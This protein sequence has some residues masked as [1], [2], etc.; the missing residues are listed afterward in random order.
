MASHVDWGQQRNQV[1]LQLGQFAGICLRED[2]A[3]ARL[4]F[5]DC[6][7]NRPLSSWS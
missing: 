5:D 6:G 3:K 7:V 1:F 2:G 4:D